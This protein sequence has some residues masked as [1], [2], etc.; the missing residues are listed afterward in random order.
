[1]ESTISIDEVTNW[2]KAL[3]WSIE[4]YLKQTIDGQLDQSHVTETPKRVVKAFAEY[5]RGYQVDP[6]IFLEKQFAVGT[7]DEM[8][9]IRGIRIISMCAHHLC[10]IIGKAH[11]AYVPGKYIVGLSK[12]PRMVDALARRRQVQEN[13]TQQIVNIFQETVQPKGCAVNIKAFHFCM[14][15]RGVEEPFSFTETTALRGV[16]MDDKPARQEFLSSL[17]H[18]EVIFP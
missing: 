16:L 2:E 10:P 17:N 7:Y 3:E 14:L 18:S 9:H 5:V 6:A 15:S 13:L 1:M 12:I 8:I 4:L 11:F